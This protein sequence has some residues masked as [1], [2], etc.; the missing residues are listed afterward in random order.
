MFK[1]GLER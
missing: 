1:H